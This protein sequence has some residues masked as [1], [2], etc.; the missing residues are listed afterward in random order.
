[1]K[2]LL[3]LIV[4]L[5]G[6]P[7]PHQEGIEVPGIKECHDQLGKLLSQPLPRNVKFLQAGCMIIPEQG[8]PV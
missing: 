2:V 7:Q 1:M 5:N 6:E 3:F 8:N 4:M